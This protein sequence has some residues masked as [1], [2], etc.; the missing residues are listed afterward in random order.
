MLYCLCVEYIVYVESILS[1]DHCCVAKDHS[2][3]FE[4]VVPQPSIVFLSEMYAAWE[5]ICI[6]KV[7]IDMVDMNLFDSTK[8]L[9]LKVAI[10]CVDK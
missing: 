5:I 4:L 2:K 9:V 1:S 6:K 10:L 8:D 3:F 7:E